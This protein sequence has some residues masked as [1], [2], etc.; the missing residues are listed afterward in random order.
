MSTFNVALLQMTPCGDPEAS[1]DKGE[2]FCRRARDAGADLALFPEMWNVG[3]TF[4]DP[5]EPGAR[6]RWQALAVGPDDHFV[7]HFRSLAAELRMGIALTYLER[8]PAAPIRHPRRLDL[9]HRMSRFPLDMRSGPRALGAR[10]AAIA[11]LF[12][13]SRRALPLSLW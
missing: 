5:A 1:L 8:W 3:Y 12:R 11:R 7:K 2:A 9:R 6:G 10:F 4:F 13:P